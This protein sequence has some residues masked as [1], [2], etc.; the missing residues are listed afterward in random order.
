MATALVIGN[1]VGSA[2]FTLPGVLAGE[3][4]P[5]SIVA[6]VFTGLGLMLLALVFAGELFS[7]AKLTRDTVVAGLGFALIAPPSKA[8][9]PAER[10]LVGNGKH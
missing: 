9:A 3:A 10:E 1:M 7:W 6:L 8:N 4:G 5:A 2:I